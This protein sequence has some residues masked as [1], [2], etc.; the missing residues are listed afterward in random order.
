MQYPQVTRWQILMLLIDYNIRKFQ[1]LRM[2]LL[3]VLTSEPAY[4]AKFFFLHQRD[5]KRCGNRLVSQVIIIS[6]RDGQ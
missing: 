4:K 3:F 1:S 5:T 6:F 2:K